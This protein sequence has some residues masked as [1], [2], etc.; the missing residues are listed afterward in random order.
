[1]LDSTLYYPEP[2]CGCWFW[3]GSL[4][5]TGYGNAWDGQ[6]V[7]GA[8]R[9]SY[10][11]EVGSIPDG[12]DLHHICGM[13][14]CV[15]PDHLRPLARREHRFLSRTSFCVNG[16]EWNDENTYI[17]SDNGKRSCRVCK[18]DR[19]R[20]YMRIKRSGLR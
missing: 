13:R 18:R 9:F 8:H 7:V 19:Q 3:E 4:S 20:E 6:R 16:H 5:S 11:K 12:Y 10:E 2:N 1:M 14:S 15:N 17:R